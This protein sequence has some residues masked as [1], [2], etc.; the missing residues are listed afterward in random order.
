MLPSL[1]FVVLVSVALAGCFGESAAADD[2]DRS[3]KSFAVGESDDPPCAHVDFDPDGGNRTTMTDG[4][5]ASLLYE[6][7][8]GG[9]YGSGGDPFRTQFEIPC[10]TVSVEFVLSWDVSGS[11]P[12]EWTLGL[13]TCANVTAVRGA[14]PLTLSVDADHVTDD[15]RCEIDFRPATAGPAD[16]W[17][18]KDATWTATIEYIEKA[19]GDA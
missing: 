16:A 17:G 18:Y 3:R 8:V 7:T 13:L 9:V 2:E 1:A 4:D 19:A 12:E 15:P 10:T 5:A 6:A 11:Y 14:S